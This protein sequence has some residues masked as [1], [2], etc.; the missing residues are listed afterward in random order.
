MNATGPLSEVPFSASCPYRN[1]VQGR[2][3]IDRD[4]KHF[5]II[6]NYL[7][8]GACQLPTDESEINELLQE[9][10]FFQVWFHGLSRSLP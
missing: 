3:F 9:V 6:L 10:E 7:R 1:D 8:D 2:L 5:R 4:P